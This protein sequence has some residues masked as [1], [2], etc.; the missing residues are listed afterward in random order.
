MITGDNSGDGD[1]GKYAIFTDSLVEK[2]RSILT[3]GH[4]MGKMGSTVRL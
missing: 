1:A 4:W 3:E 2:R